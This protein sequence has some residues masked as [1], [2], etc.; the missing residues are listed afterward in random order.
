[1][2]ELIN[3]ILFILIAFNILYVFQGAYLYPLASI[4]AI[5]IWYLKAKAF[6]LN[7]GHIPLAMLKDNLYLNT[8]PQYPLLLPFIFYL[9]YILLSG[10]NETIIAFINPIFY[11]LTIAIVYKLLRELKLTT[12]LSLLLTYVYSMLSPLLASGGRKHSGDADIFIIFLNW[13][14]LF[15]SFRFIQ[16]KNYN[17]FYLLILIIMISS[18]IKAEGIFLASILL[19]MP[20]AKK[21]KVISIMLSLIPF[22][23][24]RMYIFDHEIPNDFYFI[25]PSFLE[26]IKRSFEI[27]YYTLLEMLKINNWYI[28]W[29]V[30]FIFIIFSTVKKQIFE[31]VICSTLIIYLGCYFIFYTL[32]SI[33]PVIYVPP[34]IDRVLLQISPFFYLIFSTKIRNSIKLFKN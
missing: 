29:P 11:T 24:W 1:M 18:Q 27:F 3:R 16:K 23:L 22:I 7:H 9:I 33:S 6:Y 25:I 5:S 19:F 13:L 10:I 34:S 2:Q 20:I 28:F 32:L 17:L 12:T 26:I 21:I 15:I 30:F 4:D 8:H 14:A 31:K